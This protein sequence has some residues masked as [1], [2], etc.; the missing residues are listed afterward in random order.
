MSGTPP[1]RSYRRRGLNTRGTLLGQP[2]PSRNVQAASIARRYARCD[3]RSNPIHCQR[4]RR[5]IYDLREVAKSTG[6]Q[7]E[8]ITGRAYWIY[9]CPSGT[10]KHYHLTTMRPVM[11]GVGGHERA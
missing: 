7:L 5:L 6:K 4:N 8:R 10:T 9:P 1:K 2:E 3:R 11:E